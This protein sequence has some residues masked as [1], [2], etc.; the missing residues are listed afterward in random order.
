MIRTTPRFTTQTGYRVTVEIPEP[1]ALR[2]LA[3]I[4]AADPLIWG[5]YDRVSFTSTPGVQRFRALG[6]GRNAATE[7]RV[8]VPCVEVRFFVSEGA[9][10]AVLDAIHEAHPYEEPVVLVERCLRTLHVRGS[11]E[12]NPNRFWNRPAADWV[13]PQHR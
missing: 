10:E 7:N 13:P 6:T 8:S 3:A 4:E 1:E 2:L 12:D 11:D 9:V 5:D